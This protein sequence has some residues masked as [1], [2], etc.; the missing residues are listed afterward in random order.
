M[1]NKTY[2]VQLLT[3]GFLSENS[4]FILF[5][6]TSAEKASVFRETIIGV[7]SLIN[8]HTHTQ[9]QVELN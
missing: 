2:E 8:T 5:S 3:N 9:I 7:V 6:Q 1:Q 4:T